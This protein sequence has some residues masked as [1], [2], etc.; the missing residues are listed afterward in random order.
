MIPQGPQEE[1]LCGR[2]REGRPE[3]EDQDGRWAGH[4]EQEE[5]EE[6]VSSAPES[7]S[8]ALA[9]SVVPVLLTMLCP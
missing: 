8:L 1:T 4:R 3:E 5:Q 9:V 7:S 6:L 2:L